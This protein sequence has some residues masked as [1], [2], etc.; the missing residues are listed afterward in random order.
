M[1]EGGF[2]IR[3]DPDRPDRPTFY[4]PSGFAIPD[5]PPRMI[6]DGQ[7]LGFGRGVPRWEDDFR[8]RSTCGRWMW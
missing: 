5:V 7:P 2:S 6:V 4:S 3:H 1:H 8:S